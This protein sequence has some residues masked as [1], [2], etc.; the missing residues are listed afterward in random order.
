MNHR[1]GSSIADR[2]YQHIR[3]GVLCGKYKPGTQLVTRQIAQEIGASLNPVREAIGI[4]ATEGLL[5]HLPGAG[6]FVHAPRPEEII[7]L[8]E[9][10]QAIEPFAA[11]CAA[12]RVTASE[13][14]ILKDICS[15]QHDMAGTLRE[16][17]SSLEGPALEAWFAAEEEF[18]E[19][20][21]RA[22]RNRYFDQAL[23]RSR[24]LGDLFRGHRVLGV[25]VDLR[26]AARTWQ[27]HTRLA[28]A[29]ERRDGD[30]AAELVRSSLHH[31]LRTVL[32]VAN[33]RGRGIRSQ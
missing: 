8:Y 28:R 1:D 6:A 23:R 32:S 31:G 29:I 25:R 16:P 5:D 21:F 12:Q 7:D 33:D 18:H 19:T 11:Q 2:A 9:F 4:L 20:L 10:R 3:E 13:L 30:A 15:H 24:I 22:A 26:I 17:G 14:V 27:G